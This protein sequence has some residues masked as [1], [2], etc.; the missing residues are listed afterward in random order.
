MFPGFYSTFDEVMTFSVHDRW[1]IIVDSVTENGR[2]YKLSC[3]ASNWLSRIRGRVY[4]HGES[5][6]Q[7]HVSLTDY[8][9]DNSGLLTVRSLWLPHMSQISG[10]LWSGMRHLLMAVSYTASKSDIPVGPGKLNIRKVKPF[11]ENIYSCMEKWMHFGILV[12]EI[13]LRVRRAYLWLL[14]Q[15]F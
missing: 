12:S 7:L 2:A 8:D 1:K 9:I 11:S 3:C 5:S 10:E 6:D 15:A 4:W 13:R 14:F